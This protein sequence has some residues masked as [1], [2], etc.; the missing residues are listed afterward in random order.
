MGGAYYSKRYG[1]NDNYYGPT[2]KRYRN[3]GSLSTLARV[4][5]SV[6][7]ESRQAKQSAERLRQSQARLQLAA[8][9]E[10]QR[11][12]LLQTKLTEAAA[13]LQQR[14]EKEAEKVRREQYLATRAS[15]ATALTA[16]AEE[17]MNE[18]AGILHHTLCVD[19]SISFAD[20]RA[21]P[22]FP[23][24][25][26][27]ANL[28]E[29][30]KKPVKN[31]YEANIQRPMWLLMWIPYIRS[32]Y[33]SELEG[34]RLRYADDLRQ[35]DQDMRLRQR[36]I[37][38]AMVEY[39]TNKKEYEVNRAANL[40]KVERFEELY[41]SGDVEA[42]QAYCNMVLER[43]EYPE[44]FEHDFDVTY[45][46]DTGTATIEYFLPPAK[47]IPVEERYSYVKSRDT[48]EPKMRSAT[49]TKEA[50]RALIACCALRSIHELF[51]GD[52]VGYVRQVRFTGLIDQIN[53]VD[54][55]VS[56]V[57]LI[58]VEVARPVFEA[59]V[60]ANIDPLL[61]VIGLGGD[62]GYPRQIKLKS[63]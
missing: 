1:Y 48:I 16:E 18:I 32:R 39:Q 52:R 30:P 9:R 40:A 33:E 7:K 43:S 37:E 15:E 21:L 17:R 28:V 55:A 36:R 25:V 46:A 6:A 61:G 3:S 31:A 5:I 4:A 45:S 14:A 51:E 11:L 2:P 38:Q 26:I 56:D 10:Q 57:P 8:I 41:K 44:W 62:V 35:Y 13:K 22:E 27:P 50:Y 24:F 23:K 58:F 54:G 60:L 59:I 34:S 49:S 19:D 47:V 20:L 12:I 63:K 53:P 29:V 42:V